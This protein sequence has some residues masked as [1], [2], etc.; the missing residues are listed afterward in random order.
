MAML[1]QYFTIYLAKA[2]AAVREIFGLHEQL[3]VSDRAGH[4]CCVRRWQACA[5]R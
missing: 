5:G 3:Q 2:T 4:V 1:F